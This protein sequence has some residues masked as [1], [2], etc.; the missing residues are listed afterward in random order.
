MDVRGCGLVRHCISYVTTAARVPAMS[1][2][3]PNPRLPQIEM[4]VDPDVIPGP[5]DLN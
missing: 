2:K 4:S 1:P 5:P 3:N